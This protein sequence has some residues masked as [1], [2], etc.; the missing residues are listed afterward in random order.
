MNNVRQTICSQYQNSPTLRRLIENQNEAIDPSSD[1]DNFYSFVWNIDTAQGFALDIWGRVVGINRNALLPLYDLTDKDDDY[2]TLILAKAVSNISAA[3]AP[4]IN[5]LLQSVFPGVRCYVSDQGN[6]Q[7]QYT[8]EQLLT[9]FQLAVMTQSGIMLRPSAV[10]ATLLASEF[11]VFG[12]N[13]GGLLYYTGFDQA[14][15][16]SPEAFHAVV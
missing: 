7:M 9:D 14:P 15:F 11:P 13:E 2:R 3:N 1:I 10:D 5:A 4:S 16:I 12:F 8:F 6:M